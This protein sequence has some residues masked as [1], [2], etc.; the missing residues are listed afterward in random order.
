[1]AMDRQDGEEMGKIQSER[2]R[3]EGLRDANYTF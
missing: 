1:M 3:P 2:E